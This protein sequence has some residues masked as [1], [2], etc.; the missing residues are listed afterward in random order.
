MSKIHLINNEKLICLIEIQRRKHID[1]QCSFNDYT[2]M[3]MLKFSRFNLTA[4]MSDFAAFVMSET[5][6]NG[7]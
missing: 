2:T 6:R 7:T 4:S 5:A 3:A 1:V